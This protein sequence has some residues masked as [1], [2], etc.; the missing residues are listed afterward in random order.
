MGRGFAP[1]TLTLG[2]RF[3]PETSGVFVTCTTPAHLV[4]VHFTFSG[5]A[6]HLW[7]R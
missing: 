2:A 3:F 4:S 7:P 5:L 1:F 6:R